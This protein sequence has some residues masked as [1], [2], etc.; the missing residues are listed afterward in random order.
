MSRVIHRAGVRFAS[1]AAPIGAAGVA[2]GAALPWAR[3]GR[4]LRSGYDLA[5]VARAFG[6]TES[7]GLR[8]AVTAWL[9]LPLVAAG[10][11]ALALLGR[12]RLALVPAFVTAAAGFAVGVWIVKSAQGSWYPGVL[13]T[14]TSS[15]LGLVGVTAG[16]LRGAGR[17]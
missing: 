2:L 17:T 1:W 13:L 11:V 10:A 15:V 5:G 16:A 14:I 3:S 6:L 4:R 8:V 9:L 12:H 7:T